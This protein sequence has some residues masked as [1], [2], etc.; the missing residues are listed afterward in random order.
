MP[1][2]FLVARYSEVLKDKNKP[3]QG[4]MNNEAIVITKN[5]KNRDYSEAAV[6]LD[7]AN[8]KVVKNRFNDR[9]FNELW[10]YYIT[11]YG[12]Y[13]NK[14]LNAQNTRAN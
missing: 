11:H 14:W 6:I 13:I 7:V 2:M 5:L 12:E 1:K 9:P 3:I 4:F 10:L 8:K